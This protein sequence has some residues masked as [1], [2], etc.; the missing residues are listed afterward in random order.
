MSSKTAFS[1]T[2]CRPRAGRSGPAPH[3]TEREVDEA[4][5][6]DP[7]LGR[8][9]AEVL[10]QIGDAMGESIPYACQDWAN[11][12][13]AYRFLSNARVD[14]GDILSGHF[15]ATRARCD[16]F[17]GPILLLQ[18]TTEFSFQRANVS[19]V[20]VTKSVNSGRDKQGRIRHHTVCGMLMHSSLAVTTQGLP[21][22]LAAVKFWTRKK[23]R[24]TKALKKKV[25]PTRVPIEKK[26]SV[27]W[28]ENF[29]Q[30][31]ELLGQPERFIH[32]GDRESDIF[33]LYCLTR[34][35]GSHFLVRTCVDRLAGDGDH[36]I[37]DEMDATRL[38]GLHRIEVQ[39]DDGEIEKIVLEIRFKRIIVQPPIG[40]Q[41]RYPALDLTVIHAIERDAPKGRK[42]IVWKLITDLPVRG[43]AEAIEKIN[44]YAMRWK[45]EVFH[46]VLKSG[47]QAEASKLRTAERLAN[48]MAVFCIVSWRVLWL[49][50]LARAEPEASPSIAFTDKEIALLDRLVGDV[51]NR[52][53]E[54]GTLSFYLIKLARLGGYLARAGDS[55]PGSIVIWRGLARLTDIEIGAEAALSAL[56]GN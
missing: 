51:G 56:V 52:R 42:P 2:F 25:N 4:A 5:F 35:L 6:K 1:K 34:D 48:L 19:A 8:R 3:W 26:E 54:H 50:M 17:E 40:K 30:S 16:K 13:A 41:K 53:A 29:R 20:G 14:E 55:P 11:T 32:V 43:R 44:W 28:L 12:K 31:I 15:A 9:C 10:K 38:K 47:C 27:R 22:G 7:R 49:T 46:K 21:L 37:A 33:E 45:I 39:T 18:D 36:T 24:G 23:F